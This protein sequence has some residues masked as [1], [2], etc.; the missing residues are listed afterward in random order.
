MEWGKNVNSTFKIIRSMIKRKQ[1]DIKNEMVGEAVL[2]HNHRR[3]CIILLAYYTYNTYM[4]YTHQETGIIKL[5]L[6]VQL[7]A[8]Y[9]DMAKNYKLDSLKTI[10]KY[11]QNKS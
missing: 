4:Y 2:Y 7:C 1:I 10:K 9:R 8:V 3:L 5:D 11:I 6:K